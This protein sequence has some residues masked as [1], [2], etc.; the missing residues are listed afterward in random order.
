MGADGRAARVTKGE[1]YDAQEESRR[2]RVTVKIENTYSDGWHSEAIVRAVP[3][4]GD[5]DE[6]WNDVVFQRT[7]D[8]HGE[9]G[10]GSCYTATVVAADDAELIGKSYEWI[11]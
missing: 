5:L 8:G 11:D 6:W 9:D 3:P 7:G 10:L 2:D 1:L 4:C